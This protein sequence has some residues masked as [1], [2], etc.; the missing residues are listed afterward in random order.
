MSRTLYA[1]VEDLCTF[2][3]KEVNLVEG[4]FH[5]DRSVLA[6]PEYRALTNIIGLKLRK[7]DY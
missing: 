3:L 7:S 1:I 4:K 6:K 5:D 2:I